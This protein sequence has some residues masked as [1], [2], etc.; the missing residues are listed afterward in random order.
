MQRYN[1]KVLCGGSR[2]N[3]VRKFDLTAPEIIILRYIHGHDNIADVRAS[4]KEAIKNQEL[5]ADL[6]RRYT[7]A[8]AKLKPSR[9]MEM[10]FGMPHMMLPELLPDLE[11]PVQE[12]QPSEIA[13]P[14][15]SDQKD[16]DSPRPRRGRPPRSAMAEQPADVMA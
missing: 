14:D 9:T 12:A 4:V 6:E 3:E 13:V 8:L 10:L 11:L 7:R 16:D 15:L 2:Y 5:R 1:C